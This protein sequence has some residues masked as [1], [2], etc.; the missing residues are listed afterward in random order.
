MASAQRRVPPDLEDAG[1]VVT[2]PGVVITPVV[3]V[4]WLEVLGG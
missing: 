2:L 4:S 1:G 3:L